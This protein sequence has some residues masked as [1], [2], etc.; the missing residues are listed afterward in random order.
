MYTNQRLEQLRL[1]TL[2]TGF[3]AAAGTNEPYT[4][5]LNGYLAWLGGK[6]S[7]CIRSG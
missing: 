3:R 1:D 4:D 2:T 7:V 6:A 5:D